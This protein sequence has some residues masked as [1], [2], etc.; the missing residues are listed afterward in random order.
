MYFVP[1]QER[2]TT[3]AG[4]LGRDALKT[5]ADQWIFKNYFRGLGGVLAF[6]CLL[7]AVLVPVP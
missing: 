1:E 4:S 2:L 5:R 7:S 3:N 6:V